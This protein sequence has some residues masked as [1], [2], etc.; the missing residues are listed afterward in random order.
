VLRLRRLTADLEF[1][2]GFVE[3]SE[4]AGLVSRTQL[5][6]EHVD[7]DIAARYFAGA[8]LQPHVLTA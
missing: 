8:D 2:R 3:A 1:R 5:E 4:L 7:R 6:L